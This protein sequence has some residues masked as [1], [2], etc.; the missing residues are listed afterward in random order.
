MV[1]VAALGIAAAV[2]TF[3][4]AGTA[5]RTQPAIKPTIPPTNAAVPNVASTVDLDTGA[6]TALPPPILDAHAN[7]SYAVSP[8]GSML[9]FGGRAPDGSRQVFVANLDG[10][11][12]R[13]VTQ[14][15]LG[16]SDPSWSPD[17]SQVVYVGG[18][19]GAGNR[20]LF[21]ADVSGE[22]PVQ[23]TFGVL[24]PGSPSFSPD[25]S[26]TLFD[27][28]IG[29][30]WE[31]R[32]VPAAGGPVTTI[33]SAKRWSFSDPSYSRDGQ[34]VAFVAVQVS[35]HTPSLTGIWLAD[36][37]GG[38]A[39]AITSGTGRHDQPEW[40]PDGTQIIY[41]RDAGPYEPGCPC[42]VLLLNVATETTAVV[43]RGEHPT[44][45]DNSTL[46]VQG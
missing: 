12:L 46:I 14:D 31:I 6:M 28:G 8:D 15:P 45:L 7:G 44:W 19:R 42:Q 38:D 25:G 36:A 35:P 40:S 17:A 30:A 43:V 18:G 34:R 26:V 29:N 9:A 27:T 1:L 39:H 20:A 4:A 24:D 37:D 10:T 41:A 23:I 13:Q 32:T 3:L 11:S 21:V 5:D 33:L 16:A 2:V 22:A